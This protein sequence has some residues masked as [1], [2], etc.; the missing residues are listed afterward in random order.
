MNHRTA[1]FLVDTS[2]LAR[3]R[4][5][6]VAAVLDPLHER[7]LL[8]VTGPIEMEVMYSARN[9]KEAT[10]LRSFR[11][12]HFRL[13]VPALTNWA[14]AGKPQLPTLPVWVPT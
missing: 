14:S 7:G 11:R 8:A 10:E 1:P 12:S 6:P 9:A 3:W 2:A 13:L 4:Q 5:S